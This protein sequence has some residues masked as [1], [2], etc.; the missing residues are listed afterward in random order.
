M[1][2]LLQTGNKIDE[3]NKNRG[4]FHVCVRKLNDCQ[5]VV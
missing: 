4:T 3:H 1:N 2:Q 5:R